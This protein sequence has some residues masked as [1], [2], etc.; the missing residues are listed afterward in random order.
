MGCLGCVQP[1]RVAASE[2]EIELS[3][4]YERKYEVSLVAYQAQTAP[5]TT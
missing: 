5:N 3:F 4:D 1:R 2:R